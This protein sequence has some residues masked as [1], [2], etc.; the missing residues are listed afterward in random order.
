MKKNILMFLLLCLSM[1]A[2]AQIGSDNL[3]FKNRFERITDDNIFKT[4]GYYNWGASI[5]KGDDGK[6]HLFYSRWQNSF[7]AWLTH[8]EIAHAVSDSPSG[9]WKYK[10]TVLKGRGKGHWDA[11][12]A[13][14]PK[15]KKFGDNYYLYYISTNLGEVEYDNQLL[16][17]V[18]NT[19]YSHP[20]WKSLREHQRTGVAVAKSING[21]WKRLKAPIIE[22]SGPINILTVNPAIDKG[23]DGKYYLIVKGDKLGDKDRNQAIAV[24]KKPTGPFVM[25][26]KPVIDYLDTED[27]SLWFDGKR[28]RFYGIFHAHKYFGLITSE[29]GLNWKKAN[30]YEVYSKKVPMANGNVIL[31]DR[32]ER[33]FV[34]VEDDE[35]KTLCMAVK[36]GNEAYIVFV[37]I[38]SS[39]N[40][41]QDKTKKEWD[42]KVGEDTSS[43]LWE[44][45]D[46]QPIPSWYKD[47]KFGI[48]IH[49]GP[50][51]VPSW[52]PKGTYTEWYQQWLQSKRIFGNNKPDNKAIPS[53]QDKTYG[54]ESSYYDFGKMFKAELYNPTEW[55]DLFKRAG[56]KYVVLT[57]K[58]HDGFT[59]WP[60]KQA[61]NAR[62][63]KWN[64]AE[65]GAK[66]D[67]V[68]PYV[69]AMREAGLKAGL[70]YSLYEWYH[71]WY[72]MKSDKFIIDHY[73]PQFKE[74]VTKYKPDLL[75]ADGEWEMKDD[76]WKSGELL[77]WLFEESVCKDKEVLIN[78]RWFK[79]CR[80]K[81]GGYY[82]TEYETDGMEGDHPW[83]ENRGM[84][85]SFGYNRDENIEDYTKP[86]SLVLMLCDLVS[87]GGNLLLNVGPSADGK[88]PVIMQERLLQI[89]S[90]LDVNGEAIYGTTKWKKH[91]QWTKGDRDYNPKKGKAYVG[92]NYI[93]KQTIDQDPGMALKE[94]FFT[95]KG[96]VVY[97]ILP[98]WHKTITIKDI[99]PAFGAKVTLLGIKGNLFYKKKENDII[100][101]MPEFD[102]NW[103]LPN[104][105]YTLKISKVK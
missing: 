53:F 38:K 99:N 27:M 46:A 80:H 44:K 23:A 7:H 58:H 9:P 45:I 104:Y 11:I 76:Y 4:D 61:Q 24:S 41:A 71:P 102:P 42:V 69:D 75:F 78:D 25:Q 65:V 51:A 59:L 62:H 57:S 43:K 63:F 54:K 21:P 26:S 64:A 70:Y 31:P 98:K 101:T 81:H 96:D 3:S 90:W 103:K 86:Q 36:K 73:H 88:I 32:M 16:L 79:G 82:T 39:I 68:G 34:Y 35:P 10:E 100:V 13:H 20:K 92:G 14:N 1:V 12:T 37:P 48:F 17:E 91:C 19:G 49:W 97:A 95:S 22:P 72:N 2:N 66:R 93:L 30:N 6:Y 84:G 18:E 28:E 56:A 77:T 8:S 52:S 67:L 85:F 29:D 94:M 40:K 60:N 74:L 105:A 89:G 87:M 55:S 5:I 33:P 15:I 50:Y 83:E 47:A